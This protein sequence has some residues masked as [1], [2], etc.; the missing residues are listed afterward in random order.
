MRA[1]YGVQRKPVNRGVR[2]HVE[3]VSDEAGGLGHDAH[4]HLE[5]EHRP[6]DAEQQL[7]RPG[8]GG[9]A[10]GV[11]AEHRSGALGAFQHAR[12]QVQRN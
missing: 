8:L 5:D 2:E 1:A 11:G 4:D 6:V 3:R 10:L 9:V 7:Q 12:T